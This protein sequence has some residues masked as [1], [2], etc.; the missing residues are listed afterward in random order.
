MAGG[1]E[2]LMGP[3][4]HAIAGPGPGQLAPMAHPRDAARRPQE[5]G[6]LARA[7]VQILVCTPD[8]LPSEPDR[9]GIELVAYPIADRTAPRKEAT[10]MVALAT[11]L[12]REVRDGRFVVTQSSA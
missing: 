10:A 4:L 6:A 3:A 5:R 12:A 1:D 8:H 9:A 7:G 2:Q 11:R